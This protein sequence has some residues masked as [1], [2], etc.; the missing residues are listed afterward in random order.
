M[1]DRFQYLGGSPEEYAGFLFWIFDQRRYIA[2]RGFPETLPNSEY[3]VDVLKDCADDLQPDDVLVKVSEDGEWLTF[4]NDDKDDQGR[5]F[6]YPLFDD[7]P[8][9]I[10]ADIVKRSELREE[11]RMYWLADIVS[12]INSSDRN[13]LAV[14]KI[15]VHPSQLK[16]MWNDAHIMRAAASFGDQSGSYALR[17]LDA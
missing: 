7:Q 16:M 8:D 3:A 11:K 15:A 9:E 14:L 6:R 10:K 12:Y 13:H 2:V 1:S 4:S 5:F 17:C